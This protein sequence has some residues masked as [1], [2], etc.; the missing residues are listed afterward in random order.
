MTLGYE[1]QY[2]IEDRIRKNGFEV[3]S[4]QNYIDDVEL[5]PRDIDIVAI[6]KKES[7]NPRG[8]QLS[9]VIECKYL[10]QDF[11]CYSRPNP[12]DERVYFIDGYNIQNLHDKSR[13]HFFN[14]DPVIKNI[15][16]TKNKDEDE[17]ES[18]K[19]KNSKNNLLGAIMQLIK[20]L[21]YLRGNSRI[22]HTKGLFYSLVVYKGPGKIIDQ[23]GNEL[24]NFLYYRNYEWKEPYT[25]ENVISRNIYVDVIHE[26]H[27]EEYLDRIF[28]IEMDYLMDYVF[29]EKRMHE[30]KAQER[31]ENQWRNSAM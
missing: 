19:R 24:K 9:L 22:L 14:I 7:S 30:N 29:F 10:D 27:L 11:T 23:D 18:S 25:D 28:K 1:F 26:S 13:F 8:N 2:E 21:L 16:L 4:E 17:N 31:I 6:Q 12:K 5:K 3:F 20:A 15:N